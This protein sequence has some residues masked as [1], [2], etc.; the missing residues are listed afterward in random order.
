V[1]VKSATSLTLVYRTES[2]TASFPDP[3]DYTP[4][5][6]PTVDWNFIPEPTQAGLVSGC[7]AFYQ[8]IDVSLHSLR[9][10]TECAVEIHSL[11]LTIGVITG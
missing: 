5:T 1:G 11:K 3:T 4:T 2:T 9:L 10:Q 7:Q 8:A 6:N